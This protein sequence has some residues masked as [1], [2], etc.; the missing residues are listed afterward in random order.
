MLVLAFISSSCQ[1]YDN[2]PSLLTTMNKKFTEITDLIAVSRSSHSPGRMSTCWPIILVGISADVG[3][4]CILSLLSLTAT[5]APSS[6]VL[7]SS[8]RPGMCHLLVIA[9]YLSRPFRH[10]HLSGCLFTSCLCA[11]PTALPPPPP[12]NVCPY[13]L[14]TAFSSA[15]SV[16]SW[17]II[18]AHL[19]ASGI[20]VSKLL[21]FPEFLLPPRPPTC[22]IHSLEL[23]QVVA[24]RIRRLGCF[25]CGCCLRWIILSLV[26]IHFS[27][28]QYGFITLLLIYYLGS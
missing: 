23:W 7:W 11:R 2:P 25:E 20:P 24:A 26:I 17:Y 28:L 15:I 19:S 4:I 5:W 13:S 1:R 22:Q 14:T 9:H 3:Q 12:R 27:T 18:I 21:R 10:R 6:P 8:R 16:I